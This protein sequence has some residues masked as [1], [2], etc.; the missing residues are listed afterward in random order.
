VQRLRADEALRAELAA[1]AHDRARRLFT[2][3]AMVER[4]LATY[5]L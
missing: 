2:R 4:T 5:G 3:R 1:R